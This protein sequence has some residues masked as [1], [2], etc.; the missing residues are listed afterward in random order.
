M[1]NIYVLFTS[2]GAAE[3]VEEGHEEVDEDDKVERDSTPQ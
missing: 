2:G 1:H 3:G